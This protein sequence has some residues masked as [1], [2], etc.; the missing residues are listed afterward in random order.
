MKK[1]SSRAVAVLL[2]SAAVIVGLVTYVLKYVDKGA[3][4]A[5]YFSADGP[6]P[7]RGGG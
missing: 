5:L 3:N 6:L 7:Q 1:I 2:I 4:W